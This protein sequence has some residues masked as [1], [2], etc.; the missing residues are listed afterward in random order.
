MKSYLRAVLGREKA[1]TLVELLIV[2]AI[3]AILT[4]AF[5]PGALKAPAKARDAQ[6]QK[7][8]RDIQA[9]VESYIAEH[10]GTVPVSVASNCF[11]ASNIAAGNFNPLPVDPRKG[12]NITQPNGS[13]N[14]AAPDDDKYY[15]RATATLYIIGALVEVRGS[16]NTCAAK[17][18]AGSICAGAGIGLDTA[19]KANM[20]TATAA[21]AVPDIETPYFVAYGP[22]N[23]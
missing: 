14:T 8:V 3:I 18:A 19:T 4:V 10:S 7:A 13:C 12:N 17:L 1:F 21:S 6:R 22:T 23:I 16:G 9:A 20:D 11:L 2:I 5:L 15:Y